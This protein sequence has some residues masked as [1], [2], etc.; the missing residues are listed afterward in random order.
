M[1]KACYGACYKRSVNVPNIFNIYELATM[2]S[3]IIAINCAAQ[4]RN[5]G[6]EE[7]KLGTQR[8]FFSSI[9]EMCAWFKFVKVLK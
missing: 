2:L 8:E 9:S 6:I 1:N 7:A 4:V 5:G 3:G